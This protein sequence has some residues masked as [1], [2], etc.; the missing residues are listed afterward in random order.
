MLKQQK[1]IAIIERRVIYFAIQMAF[2][3]SSFGRG[4]DSDNRD[5]QEY[6]N[7]PRVVSALERSR[8]TIFF[9]A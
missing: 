5:G 4:K 2:S 9:I 8:N 7:L 1:S 3:P 6:V